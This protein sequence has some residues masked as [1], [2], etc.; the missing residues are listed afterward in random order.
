MKKSVVTAVLVVSAA[1]LSG[2]AG[3]YSNVPARPPQPAPV[4]QPVPPPPRPVSPAAT[5]PVEAVGEVDVV[6]PDINWVNERILE[7]G[8]KLDRWKELDRRAV[9]TD[10]G[11]S[12]QQQM[13]R[14]FKEV[15]NMVN[16][17]N[18][19]RMRLM[20]ADGE[21]VSST[22]RQVLELHRQDVSFLES[23]CGTMLNREPETALPTSKIKGD[24]A[25]LETMIDRYSSAG[26]YEQVVQVWLEI[27]KDLLS[28][29][30]IRTRLK[31]ANALMYLHQ[32]ARAAKVYAEIVD[33]L[34]SSKEQA[35]D[36]VSLRRVLADLYTAADDYD[37]ARRQ[38]QKISED[39]QN[40]GRLEEWARLQ[41]SILDRA[42]SGSPEL[43][44]YSSLLRN[45]LGFVP[46]KDGF[47]V[48][49]QAKKFLT[50]YPYSPVSSNVDYIREVA[51][52]L[53]DEWFNGILAKVDALNT[54]GKF[55]QAQE[56]LET[57]PT[58]IISPE[59]Q[60]VLKQTREDLELASAVN[61]ETAQL[62]Q[63]QAGQ[64]RWNA[65]MI[66]ARDGKYA[67][68]ID[69]FAAMRDSEY[70]DRAT[71]KIREL[72]EEAARSERRRAAQL[73]MRATETENPAAQRQLLEESR[74]VL[75]TILERYPETL[76]R[77]KVV[78]NLDRV[79]QAIAE[80]ENAGV[81]SGQPGE[82]ERA[83]DTVPQAPTPAVGQPT[84]PVSTTFERRPQSNTTQRK[85]NPRIEYLPAQ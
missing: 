28:R 36:L 61:R 76:L 53:A 83:G 11:R 7:Y 55:Q 67:E 81:S 47:S 64:E 43:K 40:L 63:L 79:E 51:Q 69:A 50:D 41:L 31:Y 77:S 33:E 39:Y 72:T 57:V 37:S 8:K 19:L 70:A 34:S 6:L 30:G 17:Y 78:A 52:R 1:G 10:L 45:F 5:E 3:E 18:T 84:D 73:F 20:E 46:R 38:Y 49:W 14:C 56:L 75:Q 9:G 60:M 68:A 54:E 74:M 26:E 59:Q 2:C 21:E 16:T 24:L 27:P 66:L 29:V 42:A 71:A 32:E 25:N 58:D 80:L 13:V 82:T 23:E 85:A 35:I 4:V 15:Q 22:R 12:E 48:V 62:Q 65:A 44:E